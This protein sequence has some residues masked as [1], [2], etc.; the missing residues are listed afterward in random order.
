MIKALLIDDDDHSRDY[1]K[2]LIGNHIPESTSLHI[3]G[4][5]LLGKELAEKHQP[6][7]IF[8]DVEMPKYS[9]F[10]FLNMMEEKNFD[11]IFTT[12]FQKYAIRALRFSELDYLVKPIDSDDLRSAIDR[13]LQKKPEQRQRNQLYGNLL[14]SLRNPDLKESKLAITTAQ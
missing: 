5:A 8:L 14:D 6:Q 1:L 4:D 2:A 13:Y 10:D 11:V 9:G 7:L 3:A 12:A